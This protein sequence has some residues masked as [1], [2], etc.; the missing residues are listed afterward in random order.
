MFQKVI[1]LICAV[2]FGFFLVTFL[3][4]S[5]KTP[6]N[7]VINIWLGL[8]TLF[9]VF[10]FF[11][12]KAFSVYGIFSFLYSFLFCFFNEYYL[13]MIFSYVITIVFLWNQG[14]FKNN[15]IIKLPLSI[16]YFGTL[17]G[18]RLYLFPQT[19]LQHVIMFLPFVIV[20]LVLGLFAVNSYT[21]SVGQNSEKV[22]H[23]DELPLTD[24]QKEILI[25]MILGKAYKEYALEN[26]VSESVIKKDATE[27]FKYYN[28]CNKYAF[29][30]KFSHFTF[31]YKGSNYLPTT[32]N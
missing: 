25:Q 1:P 32:H 5:E 8:S 9:S 18:I 29:L 11:F 14:F 12:P 23:V 24:R 26:N 4:H 17:I 7:I 30:A 28:V 10:L 2:I 31:V 15:K 3:I 27:V 19:F 20:T 6:L 13:L 21:L 16:L 22:I